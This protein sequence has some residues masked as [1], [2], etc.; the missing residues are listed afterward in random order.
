MSRTTISVAKETRDALYY[1]K[2]PEESYDEF[3]RRVCGIESKQMGGG[4]HD[5]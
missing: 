5:D 3:L 2:N 4:Q 1:R